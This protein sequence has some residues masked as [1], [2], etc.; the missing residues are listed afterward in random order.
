MTQQLVQS[1][2]CDLQTNLCL[3]HKLIMPVVTNFT[4]G[5]EDLMEKYSLGC[6]DFCS[7]KVLPGIVQD[8]KKCADVAKLVATLHN[9]FMHRSDAARD[10]AE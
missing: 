4:T 7:P 3:Y 8:S 5:V 2:V 9:C 6:D 1:S 10:R